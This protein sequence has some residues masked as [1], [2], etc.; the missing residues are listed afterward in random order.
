MPQVVG[1]RFK[2]AGKIYF[3]D[4]T[5]IDEIALHDHVVVQTSRGYEAARVVVA[6]HD[7]PESE[8]V[9]DLKQ[10]T[11][12][13]NTADLLSKQRFAMREP[14]ALERCREKIVE[15]HLPMKIVGAEY[16]F[17]GSSLL[18]YFTA[19]KRVDF[20]DLVRD[21]A[22]TFR[23]RI[24]LRQIG[25]RD[26][27]KLLGGI[28]PCGR[29]L[30]C[31][32]HLTEFRP[33]SIKMAKQQDLP[34][35]PLE[36][37]GMCG[38][39]LCCLTYEDDYYKEAKRMLPRRGDVIETSQGR[40]RVRKVNVIKSTLQVELQG[41]D[42]TVELPWRIPLPGEDAQP[43][44]IIQETAPPPPPMP[45]P[46]PRPR[47]QA[48]SRGSRPSRRDGRPPRRSSRPASQESKPPSGDTKP[49]A[50]EK[51]ASDQEQQKRKPRRRS[52]R[53]R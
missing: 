9:G 26:E 53:N 19:D 28:G 44:E 48:P 32:T 21:L 8:I 3:F 6:P 31:A 25:V 15:Y 30:C 47:E 37:S 34:L 17:D 7:V 29:L 43:G 51:P 39:L 16:S 45:T 46:T 42:Q 27:A 2:Q 24:E 23:A 49:S 36:I 52:R 20:R 1:V 14:E 13:A 35:S 11:R 38:R 4:P 40:G 12:R 10:V 41:G 33:V 18:F 50:E 5:G 22:R